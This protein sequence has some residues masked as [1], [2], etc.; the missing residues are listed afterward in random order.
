V[1]LVPVDGDG[2]AMQEFSGRESAELQDDRCKNVADL[3]AVAGRMA[4]R[5]HHI[6]QLAT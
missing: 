4:T 6:A 5:L 2:Q 1:I 3:I